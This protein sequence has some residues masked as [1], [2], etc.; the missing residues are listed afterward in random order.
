M[1]DIDDS[2]LDTPSVTEGFSP[3]L[4]GSEAEARTSGDT[5]AG[6]DMA[7]GGLASGGDNGD[8]SGNPPKSSGQPAPAP[9]YPI[10]H[11]EHEMQSS[12]LEYAMSVVVGRALPDARDGLKPV[13]RRIL[14]A[15]HELGYTAD[16]P[17]RKSA[18]IVGDVMGR[19]HPHGDSAI[20]DTLVRLAQNFAMRVPLVDGQGNFGSMD[21]DKA[22]AMRYT[23]ARLAKVATNLVVDLNYD[24]VN[25]R[26]NYDESSLEP[27][28]LPT[29]LPNLIINGSEGIAVGMA[30]KI[31]P[32]NP[33][34]ALDACLAYLKKPTLS[35][36]ELLDIMPGPDFPTGGL[37]MGARGIREAYET[38]RGAV[39][40]RAIHEFEENKKTGRT[41]IVFS[42]LPYQVN[43]ANLY[44]TIDQMRRDKLIDGISEVR[45]ESDRRGIR[46]VV[47]LRRDADPHRVLAQLHKSTDAQSTFSM[48]MMAI[49][50]GRAQQM[51]MLDLI[52][53]FV[54]HRQDV[55]RRRT[56]HQLK[57]AREKGHVLVGLAAALDNIDAVIAIIRSSRDRQEALDR[58]TS[59]DLD[60]SKLQDLLLTVEGEKVAARF[61]DVFRLS[62]AQSEAILEMRLQRLTGLERDKVLADGQEAAEKISWC[63]AVLTDPRKLDGV[64][65]DE[66][67][68][69]RNVFA[70]ETRRT[71][72]EADILTYNEE[73]LIQKQDVVVTLTHSG[74]VKYTGINQF[75]SQKRGGRGKT[76]ITMK[77]ED[78]VSR[79]VMTNTHADLVAFSDR[80]L[81]Y[82]I[83]VYR[84]PEAD[85]AQKGRP[86]VN[87]LTGIDQ[88]ETITNAIVLPQGDDA[89]GKTLL[90]V[91]ARGH[92]RRN[93]IEDFTNVPSNGKIAMKLEE[94]GDR[95]IQVLVCD[96]QD[97]IVMMTACGMA[98]RFNVDQIRIFESRYS[99]GVRGMRLKEG[100]EIISAA[101]VNRDLVGEDLREADLV[102]SGDDVESRSSEPALLTISTKG[103]GKRTPLSA[104]RKINR[105]G[106]GVTD[107]PD[108]SRIGSF[109]SA[110]VVMPDDEILIMTVSGIS[111]RMQAGEI[112]ACSRNSLGVRLVKL[113]KGDEISS[114]IKIENR[115]GNLSDDG[116]EGE[117]I[118]LEQDGSS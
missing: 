108:P 71:R 34:E 11:L 104:Y 10:V 81:S 33:V 45:D 1:S 100:D 61:A 50:G 43:K 3:A 88:G 18:R 65:R 76:G 62:L 9:G 105:G 64:V 70:K 44:A 69:C 20:Y 39:V 56:R 91:T 41:S 40:V 103:Y 36:D 68:E 2:V 94:S 73:D 52:R 102:H 67:K 111:L 80:G 66:L 49:D 16:K 29:R 118:D 48:N 83:K 37:M 89:A 75:R 77:D 13:H 19:Y 14:Y 59:V 4:G 79:L 97:E 84:L 21:G 117:E 58:L 54:R 17:F 101:V 113:T 22:A 53:A 46:L 109:A 12:Y 60:G 82:G 42:E 112:R 47:E 106:K 110:F 74:Y 90:F 7:G 23:E 116:E 28:V 63:R 55:V 51:G 8:G 72:I 92:V 93:R 95:M 31:A 5:P 24:T 26:P 32:H 57:I 85:A 96:D 87:F 30:T 38:G 27:V 6:Q 78:A 115:Y 114:V 107:R 35:V 15:M 25:Y 98:V 86:I 99:V